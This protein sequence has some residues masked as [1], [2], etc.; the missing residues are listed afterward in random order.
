M[1]GLNNHVNKLLICRSK[2]GCNTFTE[3]NNQRLFN[4]L[5]VLGFGF[6]VFVC[7]FQAFFFWFI[8]FYLIPFHAFGMCVLTMLH[9]F[10]KAKL[11]SG[12]FNPNKHKGSIVC[13]YQRLSHRTAKAQNFQL[14]LELWL[15]TLLQDMLLDNSQHPFIIF[16]WC[17]HP[18]L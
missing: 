12:M 17:L 18:V 14:V 1:Y 2:N 10:K 8:H 9:N 15:S 3:K 6:G 4:Y 16:M 5:F 13:H 11:A 7:L